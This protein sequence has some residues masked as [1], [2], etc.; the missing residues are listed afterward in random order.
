[1]H[2]YPWSVHLNA[3]H[4][5]QRFALHPAALRCRSSIAVLTPL[6][7]SPYSQSTLITVHLLVH[8]RVLQSVLQNAVMPSFTDL[9]CT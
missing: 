5:A 1:M 6:Q 2:R 8:L 9:S 3:K 7:L 4:H